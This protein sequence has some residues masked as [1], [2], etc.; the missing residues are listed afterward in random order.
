MHSNHYCSVSN[1][2]LRIEKF[3]HSA[4]ATGQRHDLIK[5]LRAVSLLAASFAAAFEGQELAGSAGLLHDIGKVHSEWQGYLVAVEDHPTLKGTGPDHKGAGAVFLLEQ[6]LPD[7]ALLIQGH[8]GGL[9]TPQQVKD[10]LQERKQDPHVNESIALAKQYLSELQQ[11]ARPRIPPFVHSRLEGEF[12]LR[13]LF[14]ALV[15]ADSLDTERHFKKRSTFLRQT[16]WEMA[17]LL[18]QFE[19]HYQ[20]FAHVPQT[21]VNRVRASVYLHCVRAARKPPGFYRLTVPTGGGKTLAS[22]AFSLFHAVAHGK[23]RLIYAIPFM[24]ITEQ[25]AHIFRQIFSGGVLEH[26][27]G[28]LFPEQQELLT[29][30]G[31]W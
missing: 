27:S 1:E 11:T 24:S 13:M 19:A 8:H 20:Q 30:E 22:L 16:S 10:W 7:L 15:D 6:G 2:A 17:H 18:A 23:K 28:L 25:T 3:A 26:H 4:N 12:F 31:L 21:P 29:R 9:T 5:H 14:S